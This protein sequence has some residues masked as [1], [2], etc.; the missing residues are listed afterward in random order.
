M[1][2]MAM[3]VMLSF[4][5]AL[6]SAFAAQ[7]EQLTSSIWL[8][9]TGEVSLGMTINLYQDVNDY[10]GSLFGSASGQAVSYEGSTYPTG[11]SFIQLGIFNTAVSNANVMIT[12]NEMHNNNKTVQDITIEN[13]GTY[14]ICTCETEAAKNLT[15]NATLFQ[16]SDPDYAT[17][18]VAG[19]QNS[20]NPSKKP[21]SRI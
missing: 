21:P 7:S 2:T 6:P 18:C 10:S 9:N 11:Y 12:F 8:Q 17:V 16:K 3:G 20:V 5:C 15:C 19:S 4:L 14:Y 13:H 1:R